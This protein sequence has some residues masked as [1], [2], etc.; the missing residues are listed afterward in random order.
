MP[1]LHDGEFIAA[2]ARDEI[3]GPDRLAQALRD[4]LEKFVADQMSQRIV[5]ALEFVDVD[6]EDRELGAFGLQ[7]LLRVALK[8][9]PVRQVGQRVVMGEMFD[10]WP[11]RDGLRSRLPS[12][13]PSRR[14]ASA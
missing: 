10:P 7:Q 9:R 1:L 8:Q 12:S 13:S 14:P 3:P 11:G 5:D 6:V 4:A 2:E